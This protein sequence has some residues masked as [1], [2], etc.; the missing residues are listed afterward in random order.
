VTG[1]SEEILLA[2]YEVDRDRGFLPS[3][4]PLV[5]M[6]TALMG[7]CE[8]A[9]ELPK[10]LVAHKLRKTVQSM[11]VVSVD[12]LKSVSE[13][14]RAMLAFS[15]IGHAYVWG[16]MPLPTQLPESL[17]I[18]WYQVAKQVGR[19]PV[20]SYASYAL[21]NW[22]RINK[23]EPIQ[24]GNIVLLQNFL[25]G[26]DEEWFVLVHVDIEAKASRA[27]VSLFPAQE[28]AQERDAHA[29]QK[30]L[31]QIEQSLKE[32]YETLARMPE[33]CDPYIYYNRVRPYIH[34][35][36]DRKLFP[37]GLLYSGVIDYK[38][39]GQH[40]RGET[41]A[42]SSIIPALDAALGV[43]HKEGPLKTHLDEMRQYMPPKHR[44]FLEAVEAGP[45]IREFVID[46]TSSN[47]S[48]RDV[49][50]QCVEWI[51]LFRT[52]HLEY[53]N[54]YVHKQHEMSLTN[55]S[56]VGTGGTPFIPYLTKHRD[57][58]AEHKLTNKNT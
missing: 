17:A 36:T 5:E 55:P 28:A 12:G 27:L 42:Q 7:W 38:G 15:F 22:R 48:L 16:E 51:E 43:A 35:F 19:P 11:P 57:E 4:D 44:A 13:C 50:N 46:Q 45:S 37:D 2:K 14:E 31:N 41:G 30:N 58:T 9:V 52:K 56:E 21:H 8:I 40:F 39:V 10:L 53:A 20:L 23:D 24:L 49:Y 26:L 1:K 32:M 25:G 54:D 33:A 47:K 6:P 34:G 3:K 18:L 29:L